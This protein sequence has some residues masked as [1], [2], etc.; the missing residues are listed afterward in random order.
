MNKT[1]YL[2]EDYISNIDESINEIETIKKKGFFLKVFLGGF[3]IALLIASLF[4]I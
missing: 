1:S 3:Y 2:N 4:L